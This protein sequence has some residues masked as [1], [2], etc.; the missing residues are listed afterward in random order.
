[1][2]GGGGGMPDEGNFSYG[3]ESFDKDEY[4]GDGPVGVGGGDG[5]FGGYGHWDKGKSFD[6]CIFGVIILVSHI[7]LSFTSQVV[8]EDPVPEVQVMEE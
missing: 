4:G 5:Q 8:Q 2:G 3:G 1:M 6:D 7:C